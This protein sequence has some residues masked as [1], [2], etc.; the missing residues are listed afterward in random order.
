[1]KQSWPA[2]FQTLNNIKQKAHGSVKVSSRPSQSQALQTVD[3]NHK[4]GQIHIK[5]TLQTNRLPNFVAA[6]PVLEFSPSITT[7]K[8]PAAC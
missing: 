6:K 5:L 2:V 7:I 8:T 3:V 4:T 1:V